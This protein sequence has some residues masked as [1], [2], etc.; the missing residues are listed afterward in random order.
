MR[1]LLGVAQLAENKTIYRKFEAQLAHSRQH[2]QTRRIPD[3]IIGGHVEYGI[4][5]R[6]R[7]TRESLVISFGMSIRRARARLRNR[8]VG[9]YALL[10]RISA[11]RLRTDARHTGPC[12]ESVMSQGSRSPTHAVNVFMFEQVGPHISSDLVSHP[13]RRFESG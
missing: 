9:A 1:N 13:R 6:I 11:L 10:P 7:H 4:R 2:K 8:C 3:T 5:I 12:K